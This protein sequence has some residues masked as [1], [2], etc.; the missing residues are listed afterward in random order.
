MADPVKNMFTALF[1][2]LKGEKTLQLG[3]TRTEPKL[4]DSN[5]P[6]DTGF[7]VSEHPFHSPP[8]EKS[9]DNEAEMSWSGALVKANV[10]T[11]SNLI[12][13]AAVLAAVGYMM[14]RGPTI[15]IKPP[16]MTGDIVI[17]DGHPNKEWKK[18]WALYASYLLGNLNPK[19]VKFVSER[20]IT[21]LSPK[22]QNEQAQSIQKI[23]EIMKARSVSQSFEVQDLNYDPTSDMIWVWGY[24]ATSLQGADSRTMSESSAGDSDRRRWTFEY[25]IHLNETG[26]PVI[27]HLRQYEGLPELLNAAGV[28]ESG[29]VIKVPKK[30]AKK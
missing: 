28:T 23:A 26:M 5:Q 17:E 24:K 2:A 27:T 4:A 22:L 15:I 21:M 3:T 7:D 10:T 6:D 8:E 16:V 12:L 11:I 25:V 9:L 13:S 30:G 19:N 1:R 18:S 20:I 29:E 14:F